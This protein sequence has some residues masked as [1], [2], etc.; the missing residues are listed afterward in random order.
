MKKKLSFS[1][2]S[3]WLAVI[4]FVLGFLKQYVVC[5]SFTLC[6]LINMVH[7]IYFDGWGE[8][9][10][11]LLSITLS[12]IFLSILSLLMFICF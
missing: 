9:I 12:I 1:A 11:D 8:E 3:L 6:Y 4:I 5:F 2:Q 10:I 7:Q